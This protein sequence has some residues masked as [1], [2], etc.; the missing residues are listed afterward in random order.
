MNLFRALA[1]F[2]REAAISLA[3]SRRVS[4]L[5][6][7]TIAVS[8]FLAGALFLFSR[9]LAEAVA[10][11]RAEARFVVYLGDTVDAA[12]AAALA[13]EV[14]GAPG[15]AGVE[16][17]DAAEAA[18]RFARSFPSLAELVGDPRHGRLP[19]S[20]EAR[21]DSAGRRS[22]EFAA[23]AAAL[24][25]RP[26]VEAVDDDRDWIAQVESVLAV[27]RA[28]GLGLTAVLLG[29]SI[30][31]IASVVRFTALLC[32][33][34]IAIMRLVGATE[35]FIR[36]PFYLGGVLQGLLGALVAGAG[37]WALYAA[38]VPR[39]AASGLGAAVPWRFF[40]L[41]EGVAL[42]GFGALAGLLGAIV[43]LGREELPGED[44]GSG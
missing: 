11:W 17:V 18:R 33:E 1:Y 10:G 30:F 38:W 13:E 42:V 15:V 12:T 6:V 23:W 32:R 37:L 16:R 40:S 29:A 26:G 39:L 35:F 5:A 20:I 3:R 44:S 2:A 22:P 36:G 21:L 9:T 25:A 27:V 4:A 43:S 19:A 34:E 14:A 24:A 28:L 31:T 41:A 8:L 7:L